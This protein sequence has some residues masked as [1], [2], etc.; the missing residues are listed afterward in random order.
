MIKPPA[1]DNLVSDKVITADI[2]PIMITDN[3]DAM[4]LGD[5]EIMLLRHFVLSPHVAKALYR[6]RH[7]ALNG[8]RRDT[9][10]RAPDPDIPA[11]NS[12]KG[13]DCH[14]A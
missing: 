4:I 5:R 12:L 3:S 10:K 7:D 6:I 14:H 2:E 8:I 9:T 13:D 1:E 11:G